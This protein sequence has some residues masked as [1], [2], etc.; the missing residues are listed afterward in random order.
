MTL[1]GLLL[2]CALVLAVGAGRLGVSPLNVISIVLNELGIP[3]F[4]GSWTE[5]ERTAVAMIRAPRALMAALAGAALAVSGAVLQALFRNPLVS[6]DVIGVSSAA[7]FG[8]VLVIMI[9]GGG[10]AL[11]SGSFAA[12][13]VAA[14]LVMLLG[15]IRTGSPVLTIVLGGIVVSAFFDALVSLVTYLADPYT[16]LPSI[17]FWLMGSFASASWEKLAL[18]TVP[19]ALG[20]LFVFALRWRVNI[21]SL[22]DEEASALGMRPGLMRG[23]LI[24][25]VSLLTAS[26]VAVAGVIGWVGLVIPH[27]VRLLVGPDHRVLLPG[28]ALLG[29]AYVLLMDTVARTVVQVEVPIG[30]LTAVIG[31]PV[32]VAVLIKRT[33]GG[34]TLA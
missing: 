27:M 20:L 9:G 15:R 1:F 30:I 22:G 12:G 21:L 11:M 4:E 10:V 14:L 7:S 19:V 24:V 18:L 34:R 26:S 16:T 5:K 31:A 23:A 3:G 17:T 28:A 13:L 29:A 2:M 25:A 32:F 6:P 8:G 33:R